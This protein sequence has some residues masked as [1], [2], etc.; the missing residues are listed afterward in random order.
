[1]SPEDVKTAGPTESPSSAGTVQGKEKENCSMLF[2]HNAAKRQ[3]FLLNRVWTSLY[4]AAI[5]FPIANPHS[6]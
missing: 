6:D 5:A 3:R 4:I 2:A 1:M